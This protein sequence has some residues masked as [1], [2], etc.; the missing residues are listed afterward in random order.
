MQVLLNSDHNIRGDLRLTEIVEGEVERVLG[1][2]DD[3]LTRVEVHCNDVNSAMKSGGNDKRC[4]IEA[5]VKG[6]DPI[7]VTHY[8]PSLMEA[9]SGACEKLERALD[10]H[11]GRL[12]GRKNHQRRDEGV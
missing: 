1:R 3:H 2:F 11:F 12:E 4:Q 8:A 5:R 9:I 7:S 10:H 6:M